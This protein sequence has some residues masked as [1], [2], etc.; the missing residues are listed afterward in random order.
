MIALR[1]ENPIIVWGEF[2]LLK[3]TAEEVF[4]YI[5]SYKG[6]NWLIVANFSTNENQFSSS[7]EVKEEVIHNY[8][9]VIDDVKEIVLKP[10]E[11]FVAKFK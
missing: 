11:A 3:D 10:Y 5:R 7:Y 8:P 6:E 9:E 4:A 2:E 1:K